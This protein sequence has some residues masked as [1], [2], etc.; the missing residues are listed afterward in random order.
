MTGE[1]KESK[2]IK[3]ITESAL[4]IF[5]VLLALIISEWKNNYNEKVQTE[6]MMANLKQEI[7][8]NQNFISSL[9]PYHEKVHEKLNNIIKTDSLEEKLF[10]DDSY[11][12]WEVA[13]NGIIQGTLNDIVWSIAK[14]DKITNRIS[15]KKSRILYEV[16]EQ[17]AIIDFTISKIIDLITSREINS[18]VLLK[19]N[20]ILLNSLFREVST[21]EKQLDY[22]YKNAIEILNENE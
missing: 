16:Y 6:K 12:L 19:E 21:Q 1:K 3:L 7:I 11:F 2:F 20:T 14:T 5:S 10:V 9:L 18:K 22:Y 13:P 17:Q 4:I 15:L 8:D